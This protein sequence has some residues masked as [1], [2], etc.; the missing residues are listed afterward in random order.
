VLFSGFFTAATPIGFTITWPVPKSKL[1]WSAAST[2][3]AA[4]A[5]PANQAKDRQR[6]DSNRPVGNNKGVNTSAR[7][8]VG[9]HGQEVYQAA[10]VAAG[11]EPG[12]VS[13]A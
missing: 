3:N 5:T 7:A 13:S 4:V 10:K 12:R 8:R 11:N 9:Y 6:G 2:V 1:A